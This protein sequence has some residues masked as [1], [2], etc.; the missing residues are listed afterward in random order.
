MYFLTLE[1]YKTY[2]IN[3]M[4][5][6]RLASVN[7]GWGDWTEYGE[8]S[9]TCGEGTQTRTHECNNPTPQYEGNDCDGSPEE[10][11]TCEIKKCPSE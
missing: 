11:R 3:S 6:C 10:S 5:Y 7:G 9:E 2:I 1:H 4:F 8:C